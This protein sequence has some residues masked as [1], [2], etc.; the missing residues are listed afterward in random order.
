MK[1]SYDKVL[2]NGNCEVARRRVND[3]FARRKL[4]FLSGEASR[5]WLRFA[6]RSSRPS[7]QCDGGP[8]GV[9]R[10]HSSAMK[11][12]GSSCRRDARPAKKS[13]GLTW[14][15]G[16]NRYDGSW[17]VCSPCGY[18][19]PEVARERREVESENPGCY[20]MEA[21]LD[22]D[23]VSE[24]WKRVKANKGAAGVDEVSIEDFPI[25]SAPLGRDCA[26]VWGRARTS[27]L[28]RF[29]WR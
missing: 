25:S 6:V 8:R 7:Q 17:S 27:L 23:N 21:I 10:G 1:V 14:R 3:A 28:Q 18:A 26:S 13:G 16:L 2:A 4:V 24:A 20:L 11:R 12:A 5:R 15:E 29:A 19:L 9:S 22:A